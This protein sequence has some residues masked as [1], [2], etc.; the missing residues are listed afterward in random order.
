MTKN[1]LYLILGLSC[2]VGY[3][4]LFLVRYLMMRDDGLTLCFLKWTF[5]IPCPS[6]GSTRA[7]MLASQGNF[8]QAIQTNPLG[9]ILA[10]WMVIIPIWIAIDLIRGEDSLYRFYRKFEQTVRIRWIAV[11][12]IALILAN[13]IWNIAKGI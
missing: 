1:R 6:C 9:L 4:W 7:V 3:G 10:A 11:L 13:W 5:G 12:L 2:A 8:L